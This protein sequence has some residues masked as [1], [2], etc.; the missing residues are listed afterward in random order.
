MAALLVNPVNTG[1]HQVWRG[2][3]N[4]FDPKYI[5]LTYGFEEHNCLYPAGV[6]A[7][8]F[9]LDS[10]AGKQALQL[11]QTQIANI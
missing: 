3:N 5:A 1:Q 7:D 6:C 11:W 10:T 2:H 8:F 4:G 9:L